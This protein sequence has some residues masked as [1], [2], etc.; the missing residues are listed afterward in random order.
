MPSSIVEGQNFRKLA[1][2]TRGA[3]EGVAASPL[4]AKGSRRPRDRNRELRRGGRAGGGRPMS[5]IRRQRKAPAQRARAWDRLN[6]PLGGRRVEP[7]F[8]RLKCQPI[9][10][11]A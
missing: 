4:L 7:P 3:R 8:R 9:S 6:L 5:R 1:G 11:S 10:S 2:D